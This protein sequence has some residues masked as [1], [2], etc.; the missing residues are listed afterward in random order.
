[1]RQVSL[2]YFE[3]QWR[4]SFFFFFT[5]WI[6]LFIVIFCSIYSIEE[7]LEQQ[8]HYFLDSRL[9]SL[10]WILDSR[11]SILERIESRIETRKRLST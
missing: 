11:Y 8:A 10:C 1:M 7:S 2:R 3:R 4:I 9:D 5:L 6:D